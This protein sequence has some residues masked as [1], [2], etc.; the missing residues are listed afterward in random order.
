MIVRAITC[1]VVLLLSVAPLA[2]DTQCGSYYV[3]FLEHMRS[4]LP[5]LTTQ[6]LVRLHR[7]GLRIFDACETG[8]LENAERKFRELER[9]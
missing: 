1:A 5:S 9:S 2:S 3:A 6:D 4:R 8:H 7:L